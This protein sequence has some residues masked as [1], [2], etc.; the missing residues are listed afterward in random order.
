M[1]FISFESDDS[2]QLEKFC[3]CTC[4]I[5]AD[6]ITNERI[7]SNI[8]LMIMNHI[9]EVIALDAFTSG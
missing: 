5:F 2:F 8:M 4:Q 6:M 3:N 9:I 1:V 7:F